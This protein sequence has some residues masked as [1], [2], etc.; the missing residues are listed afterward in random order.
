MIFSIGSLLYQHW[1]HYKNQYVQM[2]LAVWH[3]YA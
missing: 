3:I 1:E 2:K